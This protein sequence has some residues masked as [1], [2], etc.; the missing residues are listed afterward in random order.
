[1]QLLRVWRPR[2]IGSRH[3]CDIEIAYRRRI[4]FCFTTVRTDII[5]R[6]T[7]QGDTHLGT[8]W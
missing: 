5:H 1:M 4:R 8:L 6:Y 2:R 7:T 3:H